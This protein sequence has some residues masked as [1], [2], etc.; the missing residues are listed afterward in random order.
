MHRTGAAR[1]A[2]WTKT[3]AELSK[4]HRYYMHAAT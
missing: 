3:F 4:I 1:I 2:F